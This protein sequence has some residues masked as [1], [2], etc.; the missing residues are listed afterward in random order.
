[1][2][3]GLG[4]RVADMTGGVKLGSVLDNWRASERR[5][6]AI[7]QRIAKIVDRQSSRS[8]EPNS[9][10]KLYRARENARLSADKWW[11]LLVED[12]K[13]DQDA[14]RKIG[15]GPFRDANAAAFDNP[16]ADEA[17][18]AAIPKRDV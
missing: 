10:V 6:A 14:W 18:P 3:T 16:H 12:V 17:R 4:R 13:G 9:L 7:E 5:H 1:M 8:A 11:A 15:E 2:C